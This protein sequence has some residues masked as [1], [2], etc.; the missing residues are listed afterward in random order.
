[1]SKSS[2]ESVHPVVPANENINQ[3]GDL[4]TSNKLKKTSDLEVKSENINN[5]SRTL[6][7]SSA[8]AGYDAGKTGDIT[9]QNVIAAA[10]PTDQ[11]LKQLC[12][13]YIY[14]LILYLL[15]IC[16]FFLYY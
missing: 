2:T 3:S 16:F 12:K 11:Q 6:E 9:T 4:V 5:K 10:K 13:C 8:Q 1:M 7:S 14:I 15:T